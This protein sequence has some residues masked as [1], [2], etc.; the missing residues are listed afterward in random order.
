[1]ENK[2]TKYFKYAIGEVFLVVIGIL[3]A[4]QVNNANE[5]RKAKI[6]EIVV[7]EN[8]QEDLTLDTLDL[9]YNIHHHELFL[10][11][12][13][14]LLSFLQSDLKSPIDSINYNDALAL[15]SLV[16]LHESSY[17]NIQNNKI[18]II[19]N[20]KLYKEIA[21][22][23]DFFNDALT[24]LENKTDM[25]EPYA[26]KLYYFKKYFRLSSPDSEVYSLN[27][28]DIEGN[29]NYFDP[30]FEKKNIEFNDIEGAKKDE[31]FKIQLNESIYFRQLKINLYKEMIKRIKDIN[32]LINI[33]LNELRN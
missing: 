19:T 12:E 4:L 28:E 3:I 17:N 20:N 16:I 24:L 10:K 26:E 21:R 32:A 22:F 7:I 1:M 14:Q 29:E 31:A 5:K 2:T 8:L 27:Y 33:E 13:K 25:M 6:Q 11:A 30:L 9:V 18:G 23:Y 15:P